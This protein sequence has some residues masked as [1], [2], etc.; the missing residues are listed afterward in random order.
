MSQVEENSGRNEEIQLSCF[1]RAEKRFRFCSHEELNEALLAPVRAQ[2]QERATLVVDSDGELTH[3]FC[4]PFR[5]E[6]YDTPLPGLAVMRNALSDDECRNCMLLSMLTLPHECPSTLSRDY[7]YNGDP[8]VDYLAGDQR[9]VLSVKSG[10]TTSACRLLKKLRAINFGVQFDWMTRTYD[11]LGHSEGSP[12]PLY[13]QRLFSRLSQDLEPLTQYTG[14]QAQA[15]V[16]NIYKHK[17]VM[18]SHQ[19]LE[20]NRHAPL[21]SISLGASCVYLSGT[22]SKDDTPV[23]IK[24]NHGD[25]LC[26]FGANR[27]SF[28]AVPRILEV[29]A[30]TIPWLKDLEKP[31]GLLPVL[32]P[33]LDKVSGLTDYMRDEGV[34]LNINCRQVRVERL[35]M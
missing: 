12:I 9:P 29:D 20:D 8:L 33:H 2:V 4:R 24:L 11:P 30:A 34:R 32:H 13:M 16:A 22:D 25:V 6:E 35:D 27:R 23:P 17:D 14:F 7:E 21:I 31:S 26:M 18:M 1:R 28:H 3:Q 10:K 15:G 5:L 19:D